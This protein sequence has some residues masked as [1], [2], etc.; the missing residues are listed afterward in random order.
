ML[1]SWNKGEDFASLGIGHFIWYPKSVSESEKQFDESFPKL[2]TWM[3]DKGV[4]MP[5]WL[6]K[7]QGNP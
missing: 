7:S 1:T 6:L 3:Q 2:L 5:L 4:E